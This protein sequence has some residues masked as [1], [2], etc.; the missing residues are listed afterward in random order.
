MENMN[1]NMGQPQQQ[2][3][4]LDGQTTATTEAQLLQNLLTEGVIDKD[5]EIDDYLATGFNNRQ[6]VAMLRDLQELLSRLRR[7]AMRIGLEKD[8]WQKTQ[9]REEIIRKMVTIAQTSKSKG[10]AGFKWS[11]SEV[12]RKDENLYQENAVDDGEDILDKLLAKAE[13]SNTQVVGNPNLG[14]FGNRDPGDW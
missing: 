13:G 2:G 3:G 10:G 1:M 5:D 11:R 8:Q 14:N 4:G 6:E 7:V 9:V 12:L